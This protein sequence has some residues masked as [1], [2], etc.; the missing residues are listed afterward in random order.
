MVLLMR[1][2]THRG[3]TVELV[4]TVQNT[5]GLLLFGD[6]KVGDKCQQI[7]ISGRFRER[8]TS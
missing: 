5:N 1:P 3:H 4:S 2:T 6:I 8:K 7:L